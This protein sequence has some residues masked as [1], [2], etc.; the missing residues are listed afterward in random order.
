MR[1]SRTPARRDGAGPRPRGG[2]PAALLGVGDSERRWTSWSPRAWRRLLKGWVGER[3]SGMQTLE[4][5]VD[6]DGPVL[7]VTF[8]GLGERKPTTSA[9]YDG[10]GTP[11]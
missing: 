10:L 7:T 2:H 1:L 6:Q 11:L 5:A 9:M 4:P 8:N 3:M